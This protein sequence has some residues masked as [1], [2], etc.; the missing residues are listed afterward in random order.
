M[1]KARCR[2]LRRDVDQAPAPGAA[3]TLRSRVISAVRGRVSHQVGCFAVAR[4]LAPGIGDKLDPW[5]TPS[6]KNRGADEPERLSLRYP[7]RRYGR[8]LS[9]PDQS[10]AINIAKAAR[11]RFPTGGSPSLLRPTEEVATK[12]V[13]YPESALN[14][15]SQSCRTEAIFGNDAVFSESSQNRNHLR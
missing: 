5:R 1:P 9:S 11:V 8:P 2:G 13:S 6:C 15:T 14:R 10:W 7:V 3:A 4:I 12:D